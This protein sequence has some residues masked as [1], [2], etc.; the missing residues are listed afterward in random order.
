MVLRVTV[1]FDM[2]LSESNLTQALSLLTTTMTTDVCF[3]G[4]VPLESPRKWQTS[5]GGDFPF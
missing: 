2:I 4:N 1:C 3:A 5:L